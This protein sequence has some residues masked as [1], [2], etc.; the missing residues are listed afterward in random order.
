MERFKWVEI[1]TNPELYIDL[2]VAGEKV[3]I[4]VLAFMAFA[5]A[6]LFT[7]LFLSCDSLLIIAGIYSQMLIN[8]L[9]CIH[10]DDAGAIVLASLIAATSVG[11][12]VLAY[13]YGS[14]ANAYFNRKQ[15][16]LFY[17]RNYLEK[18][19]IFFEKYGVWAIIIAHYLPLVRIFIPILSAVSGMRFLRFLTFITI[20]SLVWSFS[21]I[22]FSHYLY[23]FLLVNYGFNLKQHLWLAIFV[24]IIIAIILLVFRFIGR[25]VFNKTGS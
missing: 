21:I 14:K 4:Y 12:N 25:R 15:D 13:W 23:K 9:F 17:K 3:A 24:L 18:S 19:K 1:Y 2:E 16:G 7:G 11:G 6:G 5:E 22:L 20:S 8:Q 10:N